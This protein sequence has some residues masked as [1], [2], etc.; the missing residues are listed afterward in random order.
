[1]QLWLPSKRFTG[2]SH[3]PCEV[4]QGLHPHFTDGETEAQRRV[5]TCQTVNM[6]SPILGALHPAIPALAMLHQLLVTHSSSFSPSPPAAGG[7]ARAGQ[8]SSSRAWAH[9][10]SLTPSLSPPITPR[11]VPAQRLL[12]GALGTAPRQAGVPGT[13]PRAFYRNL[14]PVEVE[15]QQIVLPA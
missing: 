13:A 3:E 1:M 12:W 4:G 11:A 14:L 8:S 2:S 15:T 7:R 10:S 6:A 9:T 5:M